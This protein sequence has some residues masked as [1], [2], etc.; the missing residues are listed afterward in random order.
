M[1]ASE[2]PTAPSAGPAG[3]EREPTLRELQNFV[4]SMLQQ[5]A[6]AIGSV[7]QQV[8]TLQTLLMGML[9]GLVVLSASVNIMTLKQMRLAREQLNE[10]RPH[11]LRMYS[12]FR[13]RREPAVKAFVGQ[14]Q[15]F[16]ETNQSFQPVLEQFRPLLPQYFTGVAAPR[17]MLVLT[18]PAAPAPPRATN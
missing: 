12:D 3:P 15:A 11:V 16:A 10:L 5:E 17:P 4:T 18:N 6:Q 8:Q 13:Q 2:P 7:R 9:L 1:N 14:L